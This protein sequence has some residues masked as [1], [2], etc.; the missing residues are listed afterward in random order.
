MVSRVLTA[1]SASLTLAALDQI[2]VPVAAVFD[3][4][5]LG[6]VVHMN[7]AEA[8]GVTRGPLEVVYQGPGEIPGNIGTFVLASS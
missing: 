5:L 3:G 7:Q 1:E 8:L 2:T 6:A 4:P